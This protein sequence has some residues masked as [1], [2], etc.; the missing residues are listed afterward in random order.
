LKIAYVGPFALRSPNASRQRVLGVARSLAAA[1]AE[2]VVGAGDYPAGGEVELA[3]GVSGVPLGELRPRAARWQKALDRLGWGRQTVDWLDQHTAT[4]DAVIVYGGGTAFAS[5]V[6][7]WGRERRVPVVIDSVEW[8]QPSHLPMGAFGPFAWDNEYAM[9]VAAP[10][11]GHV[12]VISSYL[13]RHFAAKGCNT[14]L[15]PPTLDVEGLPWSDTHAGGRLTLT[16]AGTPGRKDLL[17]TII[18]G[19][20][21]ADPEGERFE[22]RLVGPTTA[23]L[24]TMKAL[25]DG[26]P[27]HIRPLGRL[28]HEET[29]E[30]IRLS[31]F[32]PLLRP[33][34]RYAHAGFPTKVVEGLAVGTPVICNLTSDLHRYVRDTATGLV[35]ERPDPEAFASALDRASCLAPSTYQAMR[36]TAR[37]VARESF[38]YREYSAPLGDFFSR[39]LARA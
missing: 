34:A 18:R 16:Y 2:V 10:R 13:Q 5:R 23:D 11:T 17:E 35:V 15:V 8:Y 14:V 33:D 39:V 4:P 32:V 7:R 29:V 26:I 3:P 27:H 20:L 25:Q 36:R 28:A 30:L 24:V 22:L 1:G 31:H 19:F 37:R 9:R 6:S 12:I 21:I 38:D